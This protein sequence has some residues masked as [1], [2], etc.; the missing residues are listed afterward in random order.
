MTW[1]PRLHLVELE[2]LTFFPTLIRNYGTDYLRFIQ[3][4]LELHLPMVDVLAKA[5]EAAGETKIVDLCSGGGGPT[6]SLVESLR[7]RS[8][9]VTATLT[10]RFPNE[11]AAEECAKESAFCL[12]SDQSVDATDV[13]PDLQGVRTICNAFHHFAPKHA[14]R[15][16]ASAA[17]GGNSVVVLEIPERKL[18]VILSTFLAPL[19]VMIST[20][21]IRPF[22]WSRLFF[23]YLIP[24]VPLL[25]L[26]DGIVSQLRA[27]TA[28]EM[29]KIAEDSGVEGYRWEAKKISHPSLPLRLTYLVGHPEGGSAGGSV[30][31]SEG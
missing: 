19:M 22:R 5:L 9:D 16:V 24:L 12:Y 7:A 2:D 29:L 27:Y 10:D 4:R 17:R 11:V 6:P 21:W 18:S 28:E 20:P 15:V 8:L 26:W 23:T 14:A 25:C 3:A 13:P 30:E 1:I 31:E